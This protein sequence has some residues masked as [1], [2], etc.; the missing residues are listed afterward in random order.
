[1]KVVQ[2]S[3]A[4]KNKEFRVFF[5]NAYRKT[6]PG[7]LDQGLADTVA[8]HPPGSTKQTKKER[9]RIMA[10]GSRFFRRYYNGETGGNGDLKRSFSMNNPF[11]S[12]PAAW[13]TV[14]WIPRAS[15]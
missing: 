5:K 15:K 14:W 13:I 11:G 12:A 6:K 1:M 7:S 3:D 8:W 4:E 10:G 9:T 2:L